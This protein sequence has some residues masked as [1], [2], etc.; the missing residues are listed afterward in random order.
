MI[1]IGRALTGLMPEDITTE[2]IP[3]YTCSLTTYIRKAGTREN[4]PL[5][6]RYWAGPE[7]EVPHVNWRGGNGIGGGW[8]MV[9]APPCDFLS[10]GEERGWLMF[11]FRQYEIIN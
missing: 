10:N 1:A 2:D 3:A 5:D 9:I 6:V 11:H 8:D 4:A 7:T